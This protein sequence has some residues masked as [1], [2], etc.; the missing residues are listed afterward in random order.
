MKVMNIKDMNVEILLD[1]AFTSVVGP[2]NSGKTTIL[3]KLINRVDNRDIFID[4]VN[5]SEY[6]INYLRNN[7][8]VVLDDDLFNDE[9]VA[10][11]LYYNLSLLGYRIDEITN[12]IDE[13]TKYFKISNLTSERI[14][15]LPVSKKMLVKLLSYL[16]IKPKIIGLDGILSYL[17]N[18]DIVRVLKYI[19][20][21]NISLINVTNNEE[22][23]LLCDNIIVMNNN[24]CVLSGSTRS[25]L[26]GNSILPFM[27][28]KLPFI[29]ELSNNLILYDLIK[30]IYYTD[31]ELID[32]IWK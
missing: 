9:F 28:L 3:K 31:R 21:N 27:G 17:S 11:E 5:I 30:D 23:L 20:D 7:I 1:G 2:T 12:K 8:V 32:K 16:I 19:Q 18:K 13:I 22:H 25:I 10:G 4:D 14:E 26:S 15:S 29:V 6:D 24:K